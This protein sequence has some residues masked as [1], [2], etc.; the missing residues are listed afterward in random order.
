MQKVLAIVLLI[1]ALA[2]LARRVGVTLKKSFS[3]SSRH[4]GCGGG[5][6]CG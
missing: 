5:C 2:L 4:G 6:G 1:G 3:S